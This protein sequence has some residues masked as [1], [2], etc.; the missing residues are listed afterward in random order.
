MT[1]PDGRARPA[2][3]GDAHPGLAG[4]RRGVGARRVRPHQGALRGQ[5]HRG[6]AALAQGLGLGLGDRRV[7]DAARA[8]PTPASD[9][10]S[11]Q[12]PDR[13]PDARDL[14]A[15]RPV[16]AGGR[17]TCR[18]WARTPSCST[19][20]CCRPTAAPGP[21]RSPAP[22]SRWPTP[23]PGCAAARRW[24]R[25]EPLHRSVAAV[26]VGVVDGE[27]RL[28]L[29]YDEDV[30][31]ETD[32]NVVVHRRRRVRRGAGHRRGRAV[33]PA[34]ARRAARPRR[35]RLRASSPRLQR[36]ALGASEPRVTPGPRDP[37]RGQARRAA[38]DPGR[39]GRRLELSVSTTSR[40]R[41]GGRDRRHLRGERAAQGPG[42]GRRAPGCRRSPTTPGCAS[43]R[44]TA[45]RA[46]CRPAG[47]AAA[48]R[49]RAT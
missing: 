32:M 15:D 12:R 2:A 45:C 26:S 47:P 38:P 33:R 8:P 18:R 24:P 10:E 7:R 20:T 22:T 48:R 13:R 29:R 14:P 11:V 36:E 31:A 35:G 28:D 3:P 34:R 25:P 1:R 19:A 17:S 37:Q 27:P 6:R 4:A 16:A 41:R 40:R 5:R 44:S 39:A 49:R 42:G 21:R 9:R 23:S 46:C 43:T 30:A